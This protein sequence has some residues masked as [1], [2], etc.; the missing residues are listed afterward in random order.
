MPVLEE[1]KRNYAIAFYN[2]ENLFDTKNDPK[3]LDDSYTE[4]SEL[5]WTNE[6][7]DKKV[8]ELGRTISQLGYAETKH[9]PIII[10][11]A[12]VEN[13]YV[14]KKLVDSQFLKNKNYGFIHYDSP[15]ERG[16]DTALIY[17]KDFFTILHSE[18]FALEVDNP[19]G[20]R[21]Y[22]RDII[23]VKG[24]IEEEEIHILVNHWPSRHDG[25]DSTNYKRII[26]AEKNRE[27]IETI[28]AADKNAKIIIMGDFNDNPNN[29]GPMLL[30]STDLYNPMKTLLTKYEGSLSHKNT[31]N[32]FDQILLS[33]N[34]L[35]FT[36]SKLTYAYSKIYNVDYLEEKDG[37][38]MG[39]PLRT[40]VGSK[41]LGGNSD[42][43]PVYSIFS[44]KK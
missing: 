43:F 21:D 44:I 39:N 1:D 33:N 20:E 6:R 13:K 35:E 28:K 37:K 30:A 29:D 9:P 25:A 38:Y 40:F 17:R 4:N 42:H 26:A 10:G 11:V 8:L 24:K 12:E 23:Y 5:Q 2:L 41:Y 3:K 19:N 14:L 18:N 22:T 32:L 34:F 27:I 16:I 31:W 7:L 36:S 15:D